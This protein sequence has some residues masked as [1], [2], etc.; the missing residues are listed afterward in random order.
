MKKYY[1]AFIC[2][3]CLSIPIEGAARRYQLSPIQ[4]GQLQQD[5][6]R[7]GIPGS[8]TFNE[9][10]AQTIL[11]RLDD[12][13]FT[14]IADQ[15]RAKQ[16]IALQKAPAPAAPVSTPVNIETP[17][18]E[19]HQL[20]IL[21]RE[22]HQ[23]L[24][25][26][27]RQATLKLQALQQEYDALRQELT[28]Q[29]F[30]TSDIKAH[31]E[32][33]IARIIELQ[34]TD[35]LKM[36][37]Q[38]QELENR[39]TELTR[40]LAQQGEQ[41]KTIAALHQQLQEAH[42]A[43]EEVAERNVIL[44]QETKNLHTQQASM[45]ERIKAYLDELAQAKLQKGQ[46]ERDAEEILK[47]ARLSNEQ[48]Q[49]NF[50]SVLR[51]ERDQRSILEKKLSEAIKECE[52]IIAQKDAA[53]GQT[54]KELLEVER[55]Q[56]ALL[57]EKER[58]IAEIEQIKK[59]A[60][61]T[62]QYALVLKEE[63][64]HLNIALQDVLKQA[65]TDIDL[66]KKAESHEAALQN[67]IS[68]ANKNI[69]EKDVTINEAEKKLQILNKRLEEA[70]NQIKEAESEIRKTK[71]MMQHRYN[72]KE[73]ELE[74]AEQKIEALSKKHDAQEEQHQRQI[75]N[76]SKELSKKDELIERLQQNL[77]IYESPSGPSSFVGGI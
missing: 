11:S 15:L 45:E 10:K 72:Q 21:N 51:E 73:T 69:A 55:K 13:G 70:E 8:P 25:H 36:K 42:K 60:A 32:R 26:E 43:N 35:L 41:G 6:Y 29:G 12:A 62:Q 57:Q 33:E 64:E 34:K 14:K 5:F 59:N 37:S 16:L 47:H 75:E 23:Q 18:S 17:E 1:I 24:D 49:K 53:L 74:Q 7:F 4:V 77:A 19:A 3:V 9:G 52:H 2:I 71:E 40:Q 46:F 54:Q 48:A 30:A 44:Q 28:K 50:E 63:N 20:R 31:F 27:R 67:K 38:V 58:V 68:E 66:K 61:S 39:N 56:Q 65:Q 22:L 76:L